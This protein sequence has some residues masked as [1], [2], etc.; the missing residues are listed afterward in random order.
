MIPTGGSPIA[1]FSFLELTSHIFY[2]LNYYIFYLFL[3]FFFFTSP[4]PLV[5][6]NRA[7]TGDRPAQA[8]GPPLN[9]LSGHKP[10]SP[11]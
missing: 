10:P 4:F 1:A 11:L 2:F 9:S 8:A 6:G 7:P 5:L 3:L